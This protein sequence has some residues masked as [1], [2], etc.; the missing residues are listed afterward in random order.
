MNCKERN[1]YD[2]LNS[3]SAQP[4]HIKQTIPFNF[5][6]RIMVFVSDPAR[7]KFHL[8]ELENWLLRCESPKDLIKQAFH[9]A[10]V[11]GPVPFQENNVIPLVT[12]YYPNVRDT[13]VIKTISTMINGITDP[14]TNEKFQN[15]KPILALKQPPNL[16]LLLTKAKVISEHYAKD[17]PTPGIT[18]YK[19]KNCKLCQMYLQPLSSFQT[20]NGTTL[21]IK[22]LI[23]CNSINIVYFS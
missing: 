11:Q 9:K 10:K 22:R 17:V 14:L 20:A 3:Y 1:P 23:S 6:K 12:T 8:E 19:R 2:Y 15:T 18:L 16:T 13:Y 5:A 21:Q 7:M 4:F